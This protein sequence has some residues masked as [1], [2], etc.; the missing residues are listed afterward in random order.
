MCVHAFEKEKR[1]I[2]KILKKISKNQINE[3]FTS[4][5]RMFPSY[6]SNNQE[7]IGFFKENIDFICEDR[8]LSDNLIVSPSTIENTLKESNEYYK[9]F[10]KN[11]KLICPPKYVNSFFC[12]FIKKLFIK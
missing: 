7:S 2:S 12:Y 5:Q 8:V 9:T 4:Q 10:L 3:N 11:L 6:E 1:D